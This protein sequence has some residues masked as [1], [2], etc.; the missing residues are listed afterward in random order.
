MLAMRSPSRSV[1]AMEKAALIAI[2]LLYDSYKV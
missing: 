2:V 1:I